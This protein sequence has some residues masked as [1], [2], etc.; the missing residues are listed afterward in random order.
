M[1]MTSL[2]LENIQ[3]ILNKGISQAMDMM[4]SPSQIDEFLKGFEEMLK[5]I[6]VTGELLSEIPVMIAMVKGYITKEY[7]PVSPKVIATILGGFIYLVKKKDL[8]S[9]AIPIL[10]YSDDLAVLT[11]ALKFVEPELA[12]F[13]KWRSERGNQSTGSEDQDI[14]GERLALTDGSEVPVS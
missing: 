13:K 11:M 8:I 14:P 6:P 3:G 5:T 9:D 2:N 7:T 1:D 12:A 4:K 10:G